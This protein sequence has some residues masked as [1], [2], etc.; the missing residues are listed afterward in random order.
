MAD[1]E[2]KSMFKEMGWM[3]AG[4]III[5][6]ALL[7]LFLLH[8]TYDSKLPVDTGIFGTYG[9]FIGGVLGTVVA[10]YSAYLLI[11][12]FQNQAE[13]NR[14]I[15]KTNE[16]VIDANKSIIAANAKA[17]IASQRQYYQTE[18]QLFDNKFRIFLDSYQ[19]AVG[20]YT[21]GEDY[22]GR[23]A[24][25]NTVTDFIDQE[26]ENNNDYRRRS[27]SATD[28]YLQLYAE[29]QT[30]MSVHLRML[31]L[32]VSLISNSTLEEYDKVQYAKLVRGQMSSTEMLIVRYNCRSHY[33]KKMQT[34]CNQYNLIKHLPTMS[35]LEFKAYRDTITNAAPDEEMAEKMLSSLNAM[36]ITLRK[37]ATGML[38]KEGEASE[39]YKT[40][41]N[42]TVSLGISADKKT[43]TLEF[44]KDKTGVRRGGGARISPDERGLDCLSEAELLSIF[45][46]Y[47]CEL[48]L[49]SNF[50][51]YN[52]GAEVRQSGH[53]VSN[54]NELLFKITV[55]NADPLVLSHIQKE[56]RDNER[57]ELEA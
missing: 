10:L 12:T 18:L 4:C 51:K 52:S 35:L 39:E 7:V 49:I 15:Q 40:S 25:D 28:D 11:K 54:A 27:N 5:A 3:I 46:D 45:K 33:G 16:S 43:F 32:L 41:H 1:N 22:K 14:D 19:N 36:F 17:D 20:S 44:K 2:E 29:N 26:F 13:I 23:V 53:T 42:Y 24:L 55:T 50:D 57:D 31:Y 6:I 21:Y 48:F 30:Q 34:Y 9:D 38:Y 56:Y 37:C 47:L 8:Q